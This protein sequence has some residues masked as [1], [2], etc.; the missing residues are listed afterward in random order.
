MAFLQTKLNFNTTDEQHTVL[1]KRD[2]GV[3]AFVEL[4]GAISRDN[5]SSYAGADVVV[6]VEEGRVNW[7]FGAAFTGGEVTGAWCWVGV[8]ELGNERS[9]KISINR[10]WLEPAEGVGARE[11]AAE[12]EVEGVR[13]FV[14][15]V[16]DGVRSY[17]GVSA[18]G[19]VFGRV[20]STF[21]GL[22]G[23]GWNLSTFPASC[24]SPPT[25]NPENNE[26][27]SFS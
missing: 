22:L 17:L 19:G 18:L 21:G 5:R 6:G 11:G 9:P 2:A 12:A 3:W 15:P 10:S 25:L 16:L 1:S 20:K 4:D 23:R 8:G 26:K 14:P 7:D 27:A 24:V 13:C